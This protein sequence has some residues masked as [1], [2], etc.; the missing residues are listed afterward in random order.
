MK[1]Q[2]SKSVSHNCN[3]MCKGNQKRMFSKEY[4][5]LII[6]ADSCLWNCQAFERQG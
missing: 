6:P 1:S 2:T 5:M 3:L 4:Q